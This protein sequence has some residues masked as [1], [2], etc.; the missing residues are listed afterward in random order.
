MKTIKVSAIIAALEADGWVKTAQKGSHRQYKHPTKKG[1]VTV[2]GHL[3]GDVCG[4][5]LKSIEKQSG[6]KF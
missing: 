6:L 2:N 1:K 5:L 3:N 4:F